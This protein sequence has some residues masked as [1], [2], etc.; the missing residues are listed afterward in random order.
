MTTYTDDDLAGMVQGDKVHRKLYTDPD[1]FELELERIYA[2]VWIYIG[3]ESQVPNVGDYMATKI[4]RQQ[5]IMVRGAKKD[6]HVLYNRCPHKGSMVVP[7]LVCCRMVSVRV[8]GADMSMPCID[9]ASANEYRSS[10]KAIDA[11]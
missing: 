6:V 10:V 8:C 2:R 1:I 3:H 5:V 7:E 9:W 11:A 4:T